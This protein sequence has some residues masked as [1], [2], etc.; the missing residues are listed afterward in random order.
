M[1]PERVEDVGVVV[2]RIGDGDQAEDDG[3]HEE[4]EGVGG[5]DL[6][7]VAPHLANSV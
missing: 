6:H 3:Q 1:E 2:E 4:E 5:E 7:L